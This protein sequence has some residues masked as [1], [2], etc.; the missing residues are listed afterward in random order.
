M[1]CNV[2]RIPG[3]LPVT[4]RWEAGIDDHVWSLEEVVMLADTMGWAAAAPVSLG[5][6]H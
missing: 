1:H 5:S 4:L 6:G 2:C 3:T